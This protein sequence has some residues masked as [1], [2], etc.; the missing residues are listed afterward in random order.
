MA[1]RI[2]LYTYAE[3]ELPGLPKVAIGRRGEP[4]SVSIVG[5]VHEWRAVLPTATTV[6]LWDATTSALA[7]F[8]FLIIESSANLLVEA[9]GTTVAT[10][11]DFTVRAGFRQ[12]LTTDDI[13]AYNAAGSFSGSAQVI[14]KVLC[15]QTSG[16]DATVDARF[17]L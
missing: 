9:Q 13:L 8:E 14:K 3:L 1:G 7:S 15:R 11:F 5:S 17:I 16:S 12:V 4:L 6:T 10:N 2:Y